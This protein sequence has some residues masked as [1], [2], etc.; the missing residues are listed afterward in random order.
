MQYSVYTTMT[1]SARA[2]HVT[3]SFPSSLQLCTN[4]TL[5]N[6]SVNCLVSLLSQYGLAVFC[7][8][9]DGTES[10]KYILET[11]YTLAK[12]KNIVRV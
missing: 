10:E 5:R 4:Y 2:C 7:R 1:K 9:I 11:I 6:I 12:V 8:K 3:D